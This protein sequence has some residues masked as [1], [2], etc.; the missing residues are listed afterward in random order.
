MSEDINMVWPRDFILPIIDQELTQL[1]RYLTR[2]DSWEGCFGTQVVVEGIM[3]RLN[4]GKAWR[5]ILK[6]HPE[7]TD[8]YIAN[9]V[10]EVALARRMAVVYKGTQMMISEQDKA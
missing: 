8:D 9:L 4:R 1:L 7:I 6:G 2:D 5:T 3:A 10:V